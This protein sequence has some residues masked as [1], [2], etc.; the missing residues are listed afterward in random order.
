MKASAEPRAAD[1][2]LDLLDALIYGDVFDCA[3]THDELWQYARVAIDRDELRR[4][5]R[6]DPVLR[7]TVVEREGLYCLDGRSALLYERPKRILRARQM[8]RRA[9]L[10]ARVLRHS[11][12]A[13]PRAHGVDIR[14][15]LD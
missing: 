9:R 2:R 15:R 4:R 7:R 10:V 8:R 14:G 13:R 5:L 3:V 12:R 1:E 11:V 6:D